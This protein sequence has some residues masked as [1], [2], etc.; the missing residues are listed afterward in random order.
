MGF[1]K[2]YMVYLLPAIYTIHDGLI[3]TNVD[4]VPLIVSF[5]ATFVGASKR[6]S[7][8]RRKGV[9]LRVDIV[10][11][12]VSGF[13]I[14]I[15]AYGVWL[16][17]NNLYILGAVSVITAYVGAELLKTLGVS[18]IKIAGIIPDLVMMYFKSKIGGTDIKP[19]EDKKED[20]EL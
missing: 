3:N 13:V 7:E 19:P 2:G 10:D 9:L 17:L 12:Y 20:N 6:L 5:V 4:I 14:V 15:L 11:A 16:W 18:V 8:K 1:F